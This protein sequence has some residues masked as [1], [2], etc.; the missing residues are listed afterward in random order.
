[1][2][3]PNCAYAH[4]PNA[5]GRWHLLE[6]HLRA[7]AEQARTFAAAFGAGELGYYTGLW[8]DIGKLAPAF[9]QYL[10]SCAQGDGRARR[11]PDHKAAGALLAGKHAPALAL[12]IQGHH[13]GLRSRT[14]LKEWL[15]RSTTAPEVQEAGRAPAQRPRALPS[16]PR[17]AP[18]RYRPSGC[19]AVPAHALLRAGG[20]RF[21][22]YR[23][24][25]PGRHARRPQG[26]VRPARGTLATAGAKP[27]AAHGR[28]Q[29][30][31]RTGAPRNL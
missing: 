6:D 15:Q 9:Q 8:H 10:L 28:V 16:P 21:P 20:C 25:F 7:V 18:S 13:G 27:T 19:R 30:S 17:P 11:G 23:S 29:R 1:M 31:G 14:D 5:A 26:H 2:I 4:T 24:A 3:E 22:G 12:L